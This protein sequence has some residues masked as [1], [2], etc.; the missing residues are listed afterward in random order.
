MTDTLTKT[1]ILDW[2]QAV[3]DPEIPTISL[4]DLGVVRG[5]EIDETS[6]AVY[7]I[8]YGNRVASR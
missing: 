3:K 7:R 4:V 6:G 2:L 1:Q 8:S 5:V